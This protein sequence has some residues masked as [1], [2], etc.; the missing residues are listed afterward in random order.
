MADDPTPRA[1]LMDKST[2]GFWAIACGNLLLKADSI[3]LKRVAATSLVV[4]LSTGSALMTKQVLA[5]KLAISRT[6]TGAA[7]RL[8]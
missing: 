1:H 4:R 6:L 2:R 8:Q 3:S 5:A 7:H